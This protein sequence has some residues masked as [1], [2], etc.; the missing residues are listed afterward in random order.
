MAKTYLLT[1]LIMSMAISGCQVIHA[2]QGKVN[3]N[4]AVII[5][6]DAHTPEHATGLTE[7]KQ[8]VASD[9]MVASANPLVTQAGYNVL[10][11]GG[12]AADAMVAVQ[13]TLSLV[14]PQS[15]GLG[16]GAFVLY[17]DNTAK[18]L[19]TFD[20]RETAPMR[21]TPELFL[22]KD[23]QPLKFMEAVVGG[24]SV[25]TP[26]IPKLMETIHQRYG[27]LPWGKLFDTPIHLAKQGFEMS[28]RLA[29]SVEQNQQ[30]LARYPKTAAYFLPN[31]VPLQAGSLL[32]NLEF[33]D[34]VQALAAQGVKA[35]HTGKYAQNIVSVVQNAKDNPGQLSLQDLSDYQVVERLP[36][37][38]T[39]RIF[40]LLPL[41]KQ[42]DSQYRYW[43][44]PNST[45]LAH[46]D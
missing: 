20:G 32:K 9:F 33:A 28:P 18:T 34:S 40:D 2:N 7:Q 8:V 22:D 43:V 13:T 36:V 37:C 35:L 25:G 24:R 6:A 11:Q 23:G 27:V 14:E 38:V 45:R 29:I 16:G 39:Y 19:T 44:F 30:Y 21:V 12:S 1:A 46:A 41:L 4:S 10:K 15:S 5:G 3:T 17:W 26:A 31:G 42:G